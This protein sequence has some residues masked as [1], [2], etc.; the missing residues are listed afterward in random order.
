MLCECV[1][2]AGIYVYTICD[3]SGAAAAAVESDQKHP[4][5]STGAT[6]YP[7]MTDWISTVSDSDSCTSAC[8]CVA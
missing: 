3:L 6:K 8:V 2:C 7:N 4:P 5:Y 1:C